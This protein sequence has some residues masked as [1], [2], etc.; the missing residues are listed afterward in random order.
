M[1]A[2]CQERTLRGGS[3]SNKAVEDAVESA[4]KMRNCLRGNDRPLR[5]F[6]DGHAKALGHA[7]VAPVVHMQPVG[8]HERLKRY[9][10][11][12][13]PVLHHV[14]G[15]QVDVFIFA[16]VAISSIVLAC[17]PSRLP[18]ARIADRSARAGA[19]ERIFEPSRI[20][21]GRDLVIVDDRWCRTATKRGPA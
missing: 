4:Q 5:G 3:F 7:G 16:V 12:Y 21:C 19:D 6:S 13:S 14:E 8:R 20:R 1:S 18:S 2:L 15:E 10:I 11:D 9:V 17:P